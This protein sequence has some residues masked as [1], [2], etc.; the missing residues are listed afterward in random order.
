MLAGRGVVRGQGLD[1]GPPRIR[2]SWL[3]F[4]AILNSSSPKVVIHVLDRDIA[5]LLSLINISSKH[6]APASTGSPPV[7]YLHSNFNYY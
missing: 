4:K 1:H 6:P 5:K 2:S 7:A 3:D